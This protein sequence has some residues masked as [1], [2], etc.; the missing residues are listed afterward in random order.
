M[1]SYTINS[2]ESMQLFFKDIVVVFNCTLHPDDRFADMVD[3]DGN[4]SFN[5]ETS[6]Q[7]DEVMS[8]CWEYCQQ[9]SLDIYELAGEVQL[10][11]YKNKGWLPDDFGKE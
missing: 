9:Y 11:E 5:A 8:K 3:K 2:I 10:R 6:N 4:V 7:L 1:Q